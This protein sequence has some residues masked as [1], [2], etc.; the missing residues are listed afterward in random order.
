GRSR[1]RTRFPA[2]ESLPPRPALDDLLR[3][4]VGLEWFAGGP[5]IAGAP[6]APGFKVRTPEPLA[7]ATALSPSG[8]RFRTGTGADV[9]DEARALAENTQDRLERHVKNGGYLVLTV[10]PSHQQRA[11]PAL[12]DIGASPL[13][14]DAVLINALPDH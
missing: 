7:P 8:T 1:V 4:A 3:D 2:A 12:G 9:P 6:L 10:P 5:G 11:I 14:F 13:S